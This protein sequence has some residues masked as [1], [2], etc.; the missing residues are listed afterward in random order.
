MRIAILAQSYP[1]MVSGAAVCAGHLAEAMA[2]RGHQVLV[3][4]ASDRGETYL[5]EEAN[6]SIL[7]LHSHHN[8]WRVGQ[9]FLFYPRGAILRAL[10]DF[11]PEVIHSH[12]PLQMGL[13]GLEHA[14]RA[15]IPITLTI[16][17][18][19]WFAAS[20]LPDVDGLRSHAETILWM[21][22]RWLLRQFTDII[23]PTQTVSALL[24]ERT[25]LRPR[26]ISSGIDLEVFHPH[27]AQDGAAARLRLNLPP[28][29]PII[30]HVGRLDIDK[31][32]GHVVE[33]AAPALRATDAHLVIVGDGRQKSG[34]MRL[35]ENLGIKD[36]VHF[37][38][39]VSLREGLPA[40]YR[41]ASLFVTASEIET[42]GIVLLEAAASGLPIVAVG[43]TCISE[44][45]HDGVSGHLSPP[46]DV[47]GMSQSI[48]TLL[49]NPRSA[50][51]MGRAGRLIVQSHGLERTIE[52]HEVLYQQMIKGFG[53]R[54]QI[55]P[56]AKKL[57]NE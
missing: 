20:Y 28:H 33:A 11:Q 53:N 29:A 8:P 45:V 5:V 47:I 46:G 23:T 13:L 27:P 31:R 18:L 42:Q 35:C 15:R 34:L 12:E 44:I 14:R 21:Y 52:L 37:T 9:R 10:R 43:A 24:A 50:W 57:I 4:T 7:R 39:Y 22:A 38:G 19:P 2:G 48:T 3:I 25:G 41:L 49:R 55:Q 26:T 1:P 40:I 56:E 51:K 17:Q 30:L 54:L 32:V 16:H 6:L 36:R